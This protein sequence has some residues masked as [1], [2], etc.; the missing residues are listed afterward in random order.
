MFRSDLLVIFRESS[1]KY[2]VNVSTFPWE[3]SE[4]I[5]LLLCLQFFKSKLLLD[6]VEHSYNTFQYILILCCVQTSMF[7]SFFVR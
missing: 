1:V 2:A 3:F 4:V 5:K 6:T 7:R